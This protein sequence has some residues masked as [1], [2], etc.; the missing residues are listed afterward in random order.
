MPEPRR[1]GKGRYLIVPEDGGKAVAHTR[2][3]N[4]AKVLDDTTNIA[5]WQQR[6]VAKGLALRDDL[7]ALASATPLTE[8]GQLN[9][10][11]KDAIEAAAA[12]SRANVGTALH[13]FTEQVDRG[14]L[15]VASISAPWKADIEAYCSTLSAHG[16]EIHPSY[17]ECVA[18]CP[19]EY[20]PVAGTID[21]IVGW[22][23]SPIV[24]DVKT[25]ADLFWQWRSIAIQLALYSRAKSIYNP[26]TETHSPMPE[27][28]QTRAIVFHL[29]AGEGTC[30]PYT[31]DLD[32][33]WEAAQMALRVR[34]WRR[35]KD[36]ATEM[37]RAAT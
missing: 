12:S 7:F 17:I 13:S 4:V 1:D 36:L 23:G 29:P 33:G 3:T 16:I 24:A 11:C 20:E 8:K 14:E 9:R 18:V 37:E 28:D 6:H 31:V 25:G 5:K 15:D 22:Q 30:T 26:E 10:V 19:T 34:E 35:R 32:A 27:V 21:R 2:V